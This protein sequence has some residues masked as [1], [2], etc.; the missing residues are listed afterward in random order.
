[1]IFRT[2]RSKPC[3]PAAS[4]KSL[5]ER[6]HDW[7][8]TSDLSLRAGFALRRVQAHS[9]RMGH[10]RAKRGVWRRKRALPLS[11]ARAD[12]MR[13][14]DVFP[15]APDIRESRI[16]SVCPTL[17]DRNKHSQEGFSGEIDSRSRERSVASP[18]DHATVQSSRRGSRNVCRLDEHWAGVDVRPSSR[19]RGIT[20]WRAIEVTS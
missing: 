12:T 10:G 7:R 11:V 16:S 14:T 4:S 3:P 1:M 9:G 20:F 2:R 19:G 18:C 13:S 8:K 17:R 6:L 15:A 5:D